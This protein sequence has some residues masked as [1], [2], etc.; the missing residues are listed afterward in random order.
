MG[1]N[2]HPQDERSKITFQSDNFKKLRTAQGEQEAIKH[3]Q[4]AMTDALKQMMQHRTQ[5]N[6]QKHRQGPERR[7]LAG[8]DREER[9]GGKDPA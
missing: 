8:G 2:Q 5:R 4:F 7:P 9:H 3:Q 6:Q 1:G